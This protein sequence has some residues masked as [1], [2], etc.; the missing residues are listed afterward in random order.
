MANECVAVAP[1]AV[2]PS[3]KSQA[4]AEIVPSESDE[5]EP[6]KEQARNEQPVVNAATGGTLG[7]AP[8][9]TGTVVVAVPPRLSVTVSVAV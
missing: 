9:V 2:P 6:S 7:G 5:P 3:P 8:A 1:L 4:Y